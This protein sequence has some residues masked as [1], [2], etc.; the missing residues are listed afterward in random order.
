VTCVCKLTRS[1]VD[2]ESISGNEMRAACYVFQ[3]L[4]ALAIK[5][6]G[7]AEQMETDGEC[8]NVFASWGS[9]V[10]TLSTHIDTVPPYI[11]SREDDEYVW[12]RGACDAKGI[13]ASMIV[14]A[15]KLLEEGL[16]NFGLLF[17][18]GEERGSI[19]AKAASGAF[20]GSRYL[21]AGEPTENKLAL[22]SKGALRFEILT[23]GRMAHSAYPELGESAI[24]KLLDVLETVRK[25]PLPQDSLLGPTT[26]NIGTIVGGLAPNIVSDNARAEILVRVVGD[27]A[28]IRDLFA[29]A[30]NDHAQ[31]REI[32]SI[33]ITRF[34]QLDG[35]PT[36]IVSYSTDVPLLNGV[37]GKA[38][39][40][41]PG[42][43]H[44]A[45]TEDERVPK[46]ELKAAVEIYSDIV[47]GL[48]SRTSMA[49]R[50]PGAG[51]LP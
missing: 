37:W 33:P 4:S 7:R 23:S 27:P 46:R 17:L 28:P 44:S 10:V 39:L 43:I 35:Y 9:P 42:S 12:G 31:L 45:H 15:E 16:R 19:G 8:F 49:D 40:L 18:V 47:R 29:A 24:E 3:H 32:L 38:Y 13:L 30:A 50:S 48:L 51:A 26:V 11:P 41:G 6:G 21:V 34:E 36:T 5:H 25:A 14:A 22:G 20:R 1:L 2:I